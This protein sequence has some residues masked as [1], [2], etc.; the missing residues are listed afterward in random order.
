LTQH[1][2]LCKFFPNPQIPCMSPLQGVGKALYNYYL[3]LKFSDYKTRWDCAGNKL[4]D[5]AATKYGDPCGAP[6]GDPCIGLY[7]CT[8]GHYNNNTV[9][10]TET[11]LTKYWWEYFIISEN[12]MIEW[13]HL[14]KQV[15]YYNVLYC[16]VL[17]LLY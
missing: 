3:I 11:G 4:S 7:L 6:C 2:F 12:S 10:N 14:V 1:Y 17:T 16:L 5:M 13:V 15:L 9:F 8:G